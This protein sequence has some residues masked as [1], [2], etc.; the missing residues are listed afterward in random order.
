MT[1]IVDEALRALL[2]IAVAAGKDAK[3][4][5][6]T[7][8]IDTAFNG[9]LVIPRREVER[10]GLKQASTTQA[11]LADGQVVDLET[12]TCHL[13]WFG[14]VLRTQVVA[15]DGQFPLLGTMLLADRKLVIDYAAKTVVLS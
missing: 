1:G 5:R 6:V 12:F 15:N 11:V 3:R 8:W 10:L 14:K 13:D 7:V 2:D 4:E 9:G